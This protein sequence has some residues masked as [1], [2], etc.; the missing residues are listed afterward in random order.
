MEGAALHRGDALGGQLRAA[1]DQPRQ[2]GAVFHRLAR[3]FVVVGLVRLAQVGGVGVGDR[4]F[5]AHPQERS[6]GVE[7]AGEGNADF[8]LR[9]EVLE[10]RGHGGVRLAQPK[11]QM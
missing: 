8:L 9:G 1:V 10:N 7:P 3:N 4:A 5:L 2:F 11:W 6:T